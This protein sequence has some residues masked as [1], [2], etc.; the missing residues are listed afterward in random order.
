MELLGKIS[1]GVM[2][3]ASLEENV[4]GILP[5]EHRERIGLCG[6]SVEG[7]GGSAGEGESGGPLEQ[8]GG[9][10]AGGQGTDEAERY[11]VE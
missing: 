5:E 6:K 4:R 9:W 7:Q 11:G 2:E 10:A 8:F 3:E 1:L